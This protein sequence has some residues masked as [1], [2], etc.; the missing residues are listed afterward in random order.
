MV[1]QNTEYQILLFIV[2]NLL[3]G[4]YIIFTLKRKRDLRKLGAIQSIE[5]IIN[6]NRFSKTIKFVL[7]LIICALSI[8]AMMR[9]KWGSRP[10]SLNKKGFE[11]VFL[12][13]VSPS[14]LAV[15]V[16]PNRLA[17]AKV[18]ITDIID[19]LKGNKFALVQF[20]GEPTVDPPL[21]TDVT[22]FKEFYLKVANVEQI[23]IKG[24]IYTESLNLAEELFSKR[25]DVG[26]AIIIVS[27]GEAHDD[28]AKNIAEKLYREKGI[29][30][31]TV[32]TGTEDGSFIPLP[33]GTKKTTGDGKVIKTKLE[34]DTLIKIAQKGNGKFIL[35]KGDRSLDPLFESLN[36]LKKG[37][38]GTHNIEVMK[39]QYQYFILIAV[40]LF[41]LFLFIPDRKIQ[42]NLRRLS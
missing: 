11:L 23:P 31:Y 37:R 30:T 24:T 22:S 10:I 35:Y 4:L 8:F 9:P 12:L 3:I 18:V 32:G 5:K 20:S 26:K 28:G 14:M 16:K 34:K 41:I 40:L 19:K 13:D 17:Q 2:I 15:D 36:R 39:E 29:I 21:T 42:L 33:N 1:F 25:L 27:D 6:V 7:I 38:L